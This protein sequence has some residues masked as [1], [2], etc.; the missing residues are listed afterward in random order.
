[1][2]RQPHVDRAGTNHQ[3]RLQMQGQACHK[4]AAAFMM[5]QGGQW[6]IVREAERTASRNQ[7][8]CSRGWPTRSLKGQIVN[9]S[10]DFAGHIVF[11]VTA[12]SHPVVPK[13]SYVMHK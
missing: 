9:N 2:R 1:M 13:Q 3:C 7:K 10:S 5:R 6:V 8:I 12:Q 4:E 11:V